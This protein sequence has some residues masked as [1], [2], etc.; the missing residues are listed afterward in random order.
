MTDGRSYIF[1][2]SPF[3]PETLPLE[4]LAEYAS[5]LAKVFGHSDS[6][7]LQEISPG[8]VKLALK[9]DAPAVATVEARLAEVSA[10]NGPEEAQRGFQ[11]IAEWLARD[12][13]TAT[14]DTANDNATILTFRAREPAVRPIS[15]TETGCLDGRIVRLGLDRNKP[16]VWLETDNGRI[17]CSLTESKVKEMAAHILDW[18]RVTGTGTWERSSEGKWTPRFFRVEAFEPLDDMSFAD[19]LARVRSFAGAWPD[20]DTIQTIIRDLRD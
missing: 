4:R 3:T 20:S 19:V 10:G 2:L 18:V 1:H 12:G 13:G 15:V 9:V 8:S 11:H 17:L 6:V 5:A 7:H 14:L 16:V